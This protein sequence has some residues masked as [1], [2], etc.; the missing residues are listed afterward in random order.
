MPAF[1]GRPPNVEATGQ[2][3]RDAEGEYVFHASEVREIPGDLER[4]LEARRKIQK[5]PAP[6][7]YANEKLHPWVSTL[8]FAIQTANTQGINTTGDATSR[9]TDFVHGGFALQYEANGGAPQYTP[10][11]GDLVFELTAFMGKSNG[12]KV[13]CHDCASAVT[14]LFDLVAADAQLR[15]AQS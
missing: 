14:T 11:R 12:D 10:L 6:P 4:F 7:W 3:L 1:R 9:I 2:V 15:K 5:E 8:E 13:N